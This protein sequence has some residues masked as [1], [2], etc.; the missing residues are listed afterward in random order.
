MGQSNIANTQQGIDCN[1]R[2]QSW[3]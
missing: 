1:N 2:L 3:V